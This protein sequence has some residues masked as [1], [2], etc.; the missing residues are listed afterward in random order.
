MATM[1]VLA[2]INTPPIAGDRVMPEG[3]NTH[4][5]SGMPCHGFLRGLESLGIFIPGIRCMP[6]IWCLPGG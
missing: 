1:T 2:D 3:A 4:A 5:P 6:G